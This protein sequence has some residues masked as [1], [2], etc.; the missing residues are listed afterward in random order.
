[1]SKNWFIKSVRLNKIVCLGAGYVGGP[2]MATIADLCHDIQV[3]V[4][5]LNQQRID[6]WNSDALPI[7]EPGLDETVMRRRNKNLFFSTDVIRYI[8]ECDIIFVAV[9]TPTKKKGRGAGRAADMSNWELAGRS[10]ANHAESC[11]IVIEKST[12]PVRTAEALQHVLHANNPVGRNEGTGTG[13]AP[14]FVVLSNPEFLAEGT[15]MRDLLD[16]DRILIGGPQDTPEG[17]DG[18]IRPMG[19]PCEDRRDEPMVVRTVETRGQCLFGAKNFF[20]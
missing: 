7:Y 10:I 20:D 19:P 16:P 11:K 14:T 17:A 13:P 1:M 4:V 18:H 3:H 12:V 2:T 5:D 8:K 15:A 9:N 6:A